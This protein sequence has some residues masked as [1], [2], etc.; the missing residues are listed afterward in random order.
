MPG[1]LCPSGCLSVTQP[2]S[3]VFLLLP[4][5]CLGGAA[6]PV[7]ACGSGLRM[8]LAAESWLPIW[9]EAS[10]LSCAG[11]PGRSVA[12]H[13]VTQSSGGSVPSW[14]PIRDVGLLRLVQSS[15]LGTLQAPMAA[16]AP[17]HTPALT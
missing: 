6:F 13:V 4:V 16:V 7:P 17:A 10:V 3:R 11:L 1:T 15:K 12:C 2:Q 5:L 9:S 14:Q 8:K